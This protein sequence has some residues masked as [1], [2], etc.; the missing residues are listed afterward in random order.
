MYLN[1][2]C[3]NIDIFK[4]VNNESKMVYMIKHSKFG[5]FHALTSYQFI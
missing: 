4:F 2:N 3:F 5:V 1:V